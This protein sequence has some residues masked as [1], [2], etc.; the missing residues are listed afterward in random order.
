MEYN[1][2]FGKVIIHSESLL[3]VIPKEGVD[4]D[5][6]D[7]EEANIFLEKVMTQPYGVLV[8]LTNDFSLDFAGSLI[9]GNPSNEIKAA[10]LTVRPTSE[11]AMT[12]VIQAQKISF[13]DKEIRFFDVR[14]EALKWL[15]ELPNS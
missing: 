14:E 5:K 8:N 4:I 13:P 7:A 1:L 10:F 6:S 2:P 9:I 11:M 12:T 15:A 3:E